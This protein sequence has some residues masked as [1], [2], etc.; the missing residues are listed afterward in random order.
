MNYKTSS[1]NIA[2][3]ETNSTWLL[4]IFIFQDQTVYTYKRGNAKKTVRKSNIQW[5]R[6]MLIDF[7]RNKNSHINKTGL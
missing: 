4:F 7:S 1:L 5:L 6:A 3:G 2:V